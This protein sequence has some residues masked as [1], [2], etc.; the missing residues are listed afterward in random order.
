MRP[1]CSDR[2][3]VVVTWSVLAFAVVTGGVS[4]SQAQ[5]ISPFNP[6]FPFGTPDIQGSPV[7][8]V[9]PGQ[10]LRWSAVNI[11]STNTCQEELTILDSSGN[12]VVPSKT[13]TLAP[14]AASFLDF[15]AVPPIRSRTQV[16][17]VAQELNGSN[18][19][20]LLS[21]EVFDSLNLRTQTVLV[22]DPEW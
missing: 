8:G 4:W 6:L 12:P 16:R 20:I 21:V 15:R 11:D 3:A 19:A 18:C 5:E 10:T 2:L 1:K 13:V 14:G 9:A 22:P 17:T 7:V